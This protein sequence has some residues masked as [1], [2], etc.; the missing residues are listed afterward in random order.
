M[1]RYFT[2]D[3]ILNDVAVESGLNP[4][5]DPWDST[6]PSFVQMKYLL[7]GAGQELL[8]LYPWEILRR[9]HTITT[10]STTYP[11]QKYPLPDDFGYM[12]DQTGWDRDNNLPIQGGVTP[13]QWAYLEGRNLGTSTVYVTFQLEEGQMQLFPGTLADGRTI[14]FNYISRNWAQDV[15]DNG[16]YELTAGNNTVRYEPILIKR[17]LKM[18]FQAAKGFDN[19]NAVQEFMAAM[20]AWTGKSKAAQILN[21]SANGRGVPFLSVWRNLPDS[22]YGV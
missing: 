9:Q 14:T 22:N 16:L 20:D 2:V 5:T 18:K 7:N 8:E 21:A 1:S 10:D 13:Q 6:D 3:K 15:S 4:V 17:M 19:S 12:I 11:D